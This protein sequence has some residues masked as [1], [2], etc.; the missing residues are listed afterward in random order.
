MSLFLVLCAGA[1]LVQQVYDRNSREDEVV[2]F[3][4]PIELLHQHLHGAVDQQ[5]AADE[6]WADRGDNQVA[7]VVA[8]Q[9]QEAEDWTVTTS[10]K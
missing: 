6:P 1:P 7:D 9:H 3:A 8:G 5:V 2:D 4:V 10:N